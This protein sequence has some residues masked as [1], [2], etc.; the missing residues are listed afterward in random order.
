MTFATP[1]ANEIIASLRRAGHVLVA[2]HVSPDVDAIGSLLSFGRI[3]DHLDLPYTLLSQDGVPNEASGLPGV[4][5]VRTEAGSRFDTLVALDCSQLERIGSARRNL[6][7]MEIVNIDHHPTNTYF[8]IRNLVVPEA[9]STTQIV[10]RLAG[11]VG[12][13]I[14]AELATCLLAG[15]VG[16]TQGFRIPSTDRRALHDADALVAAGAELYP[17]S[18]SVFSNRPRSHLDLWGRVLST[19]VCEDGLVWATIP[20]SVR[21]EAGVPDRDDAGVV[22]FLLGTQG[23]VAAALFSE[24][25][26]GAVDTNLRSVPGIDVSAVADEF[27]GGGHRQAAGCTVNGSLEEVSDAVLSRLRRVVHGSTVRIASG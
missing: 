11:A 10:Y 25:R 27:G 20:L 19:A 8:G 23:T 21:H 24:R 4:E 1:A 17:V 2:V 9:L 5:R 16:D 6:Q 22:N 12:V 18:R 14:T 13:P 3:L 15:L 26:D 7:G